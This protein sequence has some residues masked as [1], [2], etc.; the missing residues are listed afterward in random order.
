MSDEVDD[1]ENRNFDDEVPELIKVALYLKKFDLEAFDK[2]ISTYP[3]GA[4][5]ESLLEKRKRL[6]S[7]TYDNEH[8][9]SKALLQLLNTL[10]KLDVREAQLLPLARANVSEN[11]AKSIGG[12][13]GRKWHKED[14]KRMQESIDTLYQKHPDK[15]YYWLRQQVS[16]ELGVSDGSL[17]RYTKNPRKK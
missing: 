1:R 11:E 4:G 13:K 9:L 14:Q 10:R 6:L 12:Q 5:K 2:W 16:K 3:E 8:E 7:A 17:K 15:S